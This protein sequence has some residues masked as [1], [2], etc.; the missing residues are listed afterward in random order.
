FCAFIF[1]NHPAIRVEL[2]LVDVLTA[3][4]CE[5]HRARIVWQWR[6]DRAADPAAVSVSVSE[7]I[8]VGACWLESANEYARGPVG[9]ARDGCP[10]VGN[11]AAECLIFRYLDGEELACTVGKR[12]PGPE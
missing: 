6:G 4:K 1:I 2:A 12:T 8:P 7:P 5:V 11:D 3:H 10:R 9:G